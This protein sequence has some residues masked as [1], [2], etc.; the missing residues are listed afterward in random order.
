M[1][2]IE[3][4]FEPEFVHVDSQIITFCPE[5]KVD[6]FCNMTQ[7]EHILA[8]S[9]TIVDPVMLQVLLAR[10]FSETMD[11]QKAN[12]DF[13]AYYGFWDLVERAKYW[14]NVK[15]IQDQLI[16]ETSLFRKFMEFIEMS[17][18]FAL[19]S[20]AHSPPATTKD[21]ILFHRWISPEITPPFL[22]EFIKYRVKIMLCTVLFSVG[23]FILFIKPKKEKIDSLHS[24]HTAREHIVLQSPS[25]SVSII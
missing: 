10:L 1:S 4:I 7:E 23:I 18:G 20:W 11:R 3:V 12:I 17:V 14:E 19:P 15:N 22:V 9:E 24:S 25:E 2:A 5:V 8:A 21:I 16:F 6:V 13:Q